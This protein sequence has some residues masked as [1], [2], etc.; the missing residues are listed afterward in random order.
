MLSTLPTLELNLSDKLTFYCVLP[1]TPVER[2]KILT[3]LQKTI[4]YGN[5]SKGLGGYLGF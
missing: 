1:R 2:V 3:N 5:N 4:V